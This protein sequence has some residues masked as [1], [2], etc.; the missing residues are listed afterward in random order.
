MVTDIAGYSSLTQRDETLALKLGREHEEMVRPLLRLHAG[1]E[2]KALG[3]GFLT[4]FESALDAVRC[5]VDIQRTFFNRNRKPGV[6]SIELRIGIHVGDVVHRDRDVFGDAVNIASRIQPVADPG[7]ICVS[8][9]VYEQVRNKVEFPFTALEATPL[10][11]ISYPVSLYRLELPWHARVHVRSTPWANREAELDTVCRSLEGASRGEGSILILSGEAGIGKTRLVEEAMRRMEA[12]GLRSLKARG[13]P[14]DTSPPYSYWAEVARE[15]LRDLAPALLAKVVGEQAADIAKLAPELTERLGNPGA[16]PGLDPDQERLRFYD[17]IVRFFEN[18]ARQTPLMIF[19]DDLQ[20][21][22]TA[23]LRLLQ[24]ASRRLPG[25]R[26]LLVCAYREADLDEAPVLK[27]LVLELTRQRLATQIGLKR[28]GEPDVQKLVAGILSTNQPFP[29]VVRLVYEKTGGNPFFVE[30]VVQGLIESGAI[31]QGDRGW[32]RKSIADVRLPDSV[33]SVIQQHLRR[34]DAQSLDVLRW[35][36]II[37][38]E[39][40]FDLLQRVSGVDETKLF[41]VLDGLLNAR[42]V[43]EGEGSRGEPTYVFVD[44]QV[45]SALYEDMNRARRRKY[46]LQIA[47]AMEDAGAGDRPERF[48][49]LA[50]HYFEGSDVAKSLDYTTRAAQ[51]ASE[52]YA[53]EES[54]RMLQTALEL[55]EEG[56]GGPKKAEL[57]DLLG[58]E[59][60]LAG[61]PTEASAHFREAA[62]IYERLGDKRRLARVYGNLM[63]LHAD[64]L[65]DRE[66]A[67]DFGERQLLLLQEIEETPDLTVAHQELGF[68]FQAAGDYDRAKSHFEKVIEL[69]ARQPNVDA[70]ATA[71]QFLGFASPLEEKAHAF[72]M[73]EEGVKIAQSRG[74]IRYATKL[75]NL[76]EN[77]AIIKADTEVAARCFRTAREVAT[78]M[79]LPLYAANANAML[80]HRVHIPAGNWE[81]ARRLAEAALAAPGAPPSVRN[82]ANATLALI[83]IYRGEFDRCTARLG[84]IA[85]PGKLKPRIDALDEREMLRVR[86]AL[87]TGDLAQAERELEPMYELL[88]RAPDIMT[89]AAPKIWTL[90]FLIDL[91]LRQDRVP[92]AEKV[93]SEL[94][95]LSNALAETWSSSVLAHARGL[96]AA[97]RGE[98]K[99]A[100]QLF[101]ESAKGWKALGYPYESAVS[102]YHLGVAHQSAGDSASAAAAFNEALEAF[103]R[104]GARPYV[105]KLLAAKAAR[106]P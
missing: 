16:P 106:S 32:E 73:L 17:G 81:E 27:E 31:F 90:A 49:E 4:E 69:S 45:R 1:R 30:E 11:N 84:M 105:D 91:R 46:H 88:A 40:N 25:N 83:E 68:L 70:E 51:R 60:F 13:L 39:F 12:L 67:M 104:L 34:L 77:F 92:L 75:M 93:L 2:V 66:S 44:H 9:A 50:H 99:E 62:E 64:N 28:L 24:Y 52:L 103:E 7:G 79:G 23:T 21:A 82:P 97:Q 102:L 96:V 95:R 42:L 59:S 14:G 8:G 58:N 26:W 47:R 101:L 37:G 76:G 74:G 54:Y 10:K 55:V 35:A 98:A 20:W 85:P 94:E 18:I 36:A 5:A 48:G 56:G 80:A 100:A 38:V 78:R 19:F 53:H 15:Y 89:T 63:M 41:D 33:R 6:V 57:L 22:D 72:Q 29:E 87:A 86:L 3:D 71:M 43:K 65:Q 61:Y